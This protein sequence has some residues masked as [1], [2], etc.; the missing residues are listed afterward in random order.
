MK[1]CYTVSQKYCNNRHR[2]PKDDGGDDEIISHRVSDRQGSI[3]SADG[4][5]VSRQND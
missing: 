5:G 4:V 3:E 1:A 2:K